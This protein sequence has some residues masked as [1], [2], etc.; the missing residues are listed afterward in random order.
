MSKNETLEHACNRIEELRRE[1]QALTTQV[2]Q[3]A[4]WQRMKAVEAIIGELERLVR[5]IAVALLH[6]SEGAE[7]H[8]TEAPAE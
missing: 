1:H 6:E 5:A 2:L 7:G 8:E 4:E 3:S